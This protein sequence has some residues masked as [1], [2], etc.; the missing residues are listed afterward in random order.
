MQKADKFL[1]PNRLSLG[2]ICRYIGTGSQGRCK[3][4]SEGH[5]SLY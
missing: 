1:T 2:N 4:K 3:H 5:I